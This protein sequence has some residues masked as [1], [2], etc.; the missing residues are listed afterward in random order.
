M[1]RKEERNRGDMKKRIL[2]LL[3]VLGVMLALC[4]SACAM[5]IFVKTLTGKTITLEV[6]PT[7]PILTVKTKIQEKEGI[8]PAQQRLTFDG[9]QLED[10]KTLQ[11][12][13]IQK[14][15]TLHLVK[16]PS[17]T[18]ENPC[19]VKSQ[20]ELEAAVYVNNYV[21]DDV[22][23]YVQLS[24]DIEINR[25]LVIDKTV[26]LDLNGHVLKFTGEQGSVIKVVKGGA[27]TITDKNSSNP[28]TFDTTNDLWKL[29]GENET[30]EKTETVYGGVIAGGTGTVVDDFAA[31]GGG[32][33]TEKGTK[34]AITG[35]NIIGCLI[36]GRST[37]WGG[38]VAVG[39]GDG[40]GESTE[41]TMTGGRI[42]GCE[43]QARDIGITPLGGGVYIGDGTFNMSGG[44]IDHCTSG[45][46][47]GG[48]F[49]YSDAAFTMSGDAKINNCKAGE[50][51][52]GV[53]NNDT[54]T[55]TMNGGRIS[56]C[57]AQKGGGACLT[58]GNV[59]TM[60]DGIIEDDLYIQVT[61]MNA[62]GGTVK[63]S[64]FI[65]G[66]IQTMP[67]NMPG[68]TFSGNVENYGGTIAGGRFTGEVINR[69]HEWG[70]GY[71]SRITGGEFSGKVTNESYGIISGGSFTDEVIDDGL[72]DAWVVTFDTQGGSDVPRQVRANVPA[73]RPEDPTKDNCTFGGWYT[74]RK[75]TEK[76][77]FDEDVTENLTL[78]AKWIGDEQPAPE[79]V[80][81]WWAGLLPAL[82]DELPFT[83]VKSGDWFYDDVRYVYGSGLM[84]GTSATKFSP[85]ASTTR[86]MVLTILARM[87]GVNTSGTPWYAAGRDWAVANGISD[88]TNMEAPVT[89]EQLAA[90][91][92]RYA[93]FKGRDAAT[94]ERELS[95]FADAGSV[96][97]W[98]LD[99]MQ[100]AVGTGLISGSNG[101]LCPQSNASR[102]EVAA[103]LARFAEYIG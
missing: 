101:L 87:E 68:T 64:V 75:C 12:Y 28:H 102:A 73:A 35:G 33:Y 72:T 20:G 7:D 4:V 86:G 31:Y 39:V 92:Y 88:G 90:I 60:T 54:G 15:S 67:E 99:A 58:S 61:Q 100:W 53:F 95:V 89:R 48:V 36:T 16:K 18:E 76:Y 63:G 77:N 57:T 44:S 6:E 81:P 5:Q 23:N 26:T 17:Y 43:A 97:G 59:F 47:G 9:K 42:A 3:M 46:Y 41:F 52:G 66:T 21:D 62:E 25:T 103:I 70:A 38:G 65:E 78:Y 1:K 8:P 82:D 29:L 94:L 98:A 69:N 37:S 24:N 30:A 79:P 56:G 2:R 14:E 55:F 96:S 40:T 19:E 10:D 32:I 74:D 83:D 51:G 80:L 13:G 50:C 71:P 11:D 34:L 93:S 49:M 45:V 91:L 27:L 84:N 22:H 85:S